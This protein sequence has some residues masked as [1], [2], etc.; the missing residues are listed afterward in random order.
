MWD[1]R[2]KW[3]LSNILCPILY[4]NICDST[5]NLLRFD[6]LN[7]KSIWKFKSNNLHVL[8]DLLLKLQRASISFKSWFG[9]SMTLKLLSGVWHLDLLWESVNDL[10]YTLVWKFSSLPWFWRCE[11]H[12][13]PLS[14][15][16]EL[17]RILEVPDWDLEY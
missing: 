7:I 4:A 15:D 10:W 5:W 9:L 1:L 13:F 14:P 2:L 12:P 3:N 16:L 8:K 11:E 17:W 6:P